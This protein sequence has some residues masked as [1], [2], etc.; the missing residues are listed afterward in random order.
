[1]RMRAGVVGLAVA[2]LVASAAAAGAEGADG[3]ADEDGVR[4][5]VGTTPPSVRATLTQ[6]LDPESDTVTVIGRG[7]GHGIG[8]S[9][10]GAEGAARRGLS[11]REI[12][13]FYY[14][15]TRFV[16]RHEFVRVHLTADTSD[17]VV[18]RAASRLRVRDSGDWRTF[19]LPERDGIRAW[20]IAAARGKPNR[21]AVQYRTGDGW[22][23]WQVPGRGLLRGDGAFRRPGSLKLVL[24]GGD[25]RRYRG[26]LR[27]ATPDSDRDERDTVNVLRLQNYLKGVVPQEMP[28]SWSK[29]ALRAQAVAARS[30]ALHL[31]GSGSDGHFD[32]CDTTSCQVYDG[33]DA[34]A[35]PASDA[36][37]ATSGVTVARGRAAALTMFS[38]SSGGWT[39]SGGLPYLRAHRDRYDRWKG[40]PMRHWDYRL[41]AGEIE[42][43]Y[44]ELGRF[45]KAKVAGREGHGAW[46][47]RVRRVM[48]IGSR[49]RVWVGGEDFRMDFGLP[50][51]WFRLR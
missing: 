32:L 45:R 41:G 36:V 39:A 18:V 27:A 28:P 14:P 44:P 51:S 8:M 43:V 9:Q 13:R 46:G 2:A 38:S 49:D 5:P 47:G 1:M 20:R 17:P 6:A 37:R 25:V 26:S 30:Y 23:R 7:Y 22:H 11:Y 4:Q 31:M 19:R 21:S 35:G 48:L 12:L 15:N 50:S 40:N 34:E 3:A 33:R 29:H 24:P 42:Q 10:Y 16:E